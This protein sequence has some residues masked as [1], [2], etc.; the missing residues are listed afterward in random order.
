MHV[1]RCDVC[2]CV[3]SYDLKTKLRARTVVPDP[4]KNH[5][6]A[7]ATRGG[8]GTIDTKLYHNTNVKTES[9][10]TMPNTNNILCLSIHAPPK[11]RTV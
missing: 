1:A 7:T 2:I 5:D 8:K 10:S 3:V 9:D 6:K 4:A 11:Y